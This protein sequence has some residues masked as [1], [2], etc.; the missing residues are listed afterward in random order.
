[1]E[2]CAGASELEPELV[3][4][5]PEMPRLEQISRDLITQN[6]YSALFE[7]EIMK[8]EA[9]CGAVAALLPS[10]YRA[11]RLRGEAAERYDKRRRNQLRDEMAI[12]LHANN[13]QHWSPS[14][15]ARSVAL[16]RLLQIPEGQ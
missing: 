8:N 16:V 15:V 10:S 3:T 11:R 2:E 6:D 12:K 13:Q 1:M 7:A 9:A 5:E 4:L 14:L